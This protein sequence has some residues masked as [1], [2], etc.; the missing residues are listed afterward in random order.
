MCAGMNNKTHMSCKVWMRGKHVER[1]NACSV[2]VI[3]RGGQ[4][5]LYSIIL[6]ILCLEI[7]PLASL[8]PLTTKCGKV[9]WPA[10]LQ[11]V[12]AASSLKIRSV[13]SVKNTLGCLWK[14]LAI[15]SIWFQNASGAAGCKGM[16][17]CVKEALIREQESYPASNS[18]LVTS[19]QCHAKVSCHRCVRRRQ[20]C[21]H[22]SISHSAWESDVRQVW[23]LVR[24]KC[25]AACSATSWRG[26]E[27]RGKSY[28]WHIS[29]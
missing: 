21:H 12:D 8:F 16:S 22:G 29:L 17:H 10:R 18:Y 27:T 7:N 20:R 2:I 28:W 19:L 1:C 23:F 6:P 14:I 3:Y 9:F 26:S 15:Q 5:I 25:A 4:I 11:R 24:A 13:L